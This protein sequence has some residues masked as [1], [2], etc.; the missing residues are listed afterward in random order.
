MGR[1]EV[2]AEG[3]PVPLV[4]GVL[5]KGMGVDRIEGSLEAAAEGEGLVGG[6]RS[7]PARRSSASSAR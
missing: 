3:V 5:E 6:P 2:S 1:M 7:R 4:L